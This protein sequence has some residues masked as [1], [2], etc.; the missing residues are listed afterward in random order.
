MIP[1]SEISTE[2]HPDISLNTFM[3]IK[4]MALVFFTHEISEASYRQATGT[5]DK[6]Q[7]PHPLLI[8]HLL[9]ELQGKVAKRLKHPNV[10]GSRMIR[11]LRKS[12]KH[13]NIWLQAKQLFYSEKQSSFSTGTDNNDQKFFN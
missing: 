7:Q 13:L 6:L 10:N 3:C 9:D 8:V 5:S 2:L 1:F 12:I 11:R 4:E